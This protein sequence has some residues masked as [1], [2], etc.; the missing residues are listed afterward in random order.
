MYCRKSS[1]CS[2][3]WSHAILSKLWVS[4]MNVHSSHVIR[5]DISMS[6]RCPIENISSRRDVFF[7]LMWVTV[8]FCCRWDMITPFADE[9]NLT[10]EI[11]FIGKTMNL[12]KD[13]YRSQTS[14]WEISLNSPFVAVTISFSHWWSRKSVWHSNQQDY[15]TSHR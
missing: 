14:R 9:I 7:C 13:S 8:T 1:C 15:I 6:Q 4:P 3:L 12:R 10:D 2:S 11:N 5:Y